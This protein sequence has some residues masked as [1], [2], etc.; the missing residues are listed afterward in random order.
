MADLEKLWRDAS[1]KYPVCIKG[2]V[3]KNMVLDAITDGAYD[4]EALKKVLPLCPDNECAKIS[5]TGR[6][7]KENAE[8]LLKIYVPIYKMMRAGAAGC[9]HEHK[10]PRAMLPRPECVRGQQG[11]CGSC[12]DC[13]IGWKDED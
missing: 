8:M 3:T 13:S 4:L 12:R 2:K 10:P 9:K 6:G 11:E 5:A 1:P 7:C